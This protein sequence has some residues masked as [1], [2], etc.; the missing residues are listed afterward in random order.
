MANRCPS[1]GGTLRFDVQKQKLVCEY[2]ESEFDPDGVEETKGAVESP[3]FNG[4]TM[5]AKI[6]T[7]PNCGA[8]VFAT[9]LDAVEY[10]S[11]CGTF[12]T[13]E[14]RLAKIQ[15]PSYIIPFGV[16]KEK[17]LELY[18]EELKK[19]HFLPS[20]MNEKNAES[21]FRN[22]Y[23]PFWLYTQK[24]K[25]DA[26]VKFKTTVDYVEQDAEFRQKY[27]VGK[28]R[29]EVTAKVSGNVEGMI[30][31][32][33]VNLEDRISDEIKN[34]P[35]DSLKEFK[36]NV[37]A[38][39]YA[40]VADVQSKTYSEDAC[41]WGFESVAPKV[42]ETVENK[43]RSE[44]EGD[45]GKS[46]KFFTD[47]SLSQN[48]DECCE[49][50]SKLAM[51]PV[52]FLTYKIK[53]RVFYSVINGF[54]GK[55]FAEIP[56]AIKKFLLWSFVAAV[57]F[58][59]ILELL[60]GFAFNYDFA[61]PKNVNDIWFITLI[62]SIGE[63][64]FDRRPFLKKLAR[65]KNKDD[66]KGYK[67]VGT[68]TSDKKTKKMDFTAVAIVIALVVSFV[69][70]RLFGGEKSVMPGYVAAVINIITIF[71]SIASKIRAHNLAC[72]RPVPHFFDKNKEAGK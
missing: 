14:S 19:A 35:M 40:D 2:C 5:D 64:I 61:N 10:C 71:A 56:V 44:V 67:A 7:C 26:E 65:E 28:R 60:F 18:K 69:I 41:K 62:V 68:E 55:V 27:D 30:Y 50:D 1:C 24:F 72:S 58:F 4:E 25:P 11:Y 45:L 29:Y 37:M 8:E 39:S 70:V 6:F 38:G 66:D 47:V 17:C 53:D 16:T 34:F 63:L 54:T 20:Y 32:A 52:W 3:S 42:Q 13:L 9:D 21:K 31:D 49:S 36:R 15:K 12:V 22:F 43:K 46:A 57:P 23:I 33:S 48:I 51:L 59:L